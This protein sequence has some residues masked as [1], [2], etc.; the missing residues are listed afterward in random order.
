MGAGAAA[1]IQQSRKEV[2]APAGLRGCANGS[3]PVQFRQPAAE[4]VRKR[5]VPGRG[6]PGERG[7]GFPKDGLVM[8]IK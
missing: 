1:V 6:Q 7:D 4:D 5:K 2:K 3:G 8:S